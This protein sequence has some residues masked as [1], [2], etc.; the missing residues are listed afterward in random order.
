MEFAK[1]VI[2]CLFAAIAYGVAHDQVTAHLCVEYFTIAHPPMFPTKSPFLL[3]LGWGI[4]ATWWVGLPLGLLAALAARIG[5]RPKLSL[6]DIRPMIFALV[7]LMALCALCAGVLGA[8]LVATG[9]QPVLGGWAEAI[10]RNKWI[11]FNADAWAHLASY[12]SGVT[13]G[14]AIIVYIAVRRLRMG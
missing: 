9:R 7:A 4:I 5:N 10:P 8:W 3:A 12:A 13:G 1:I 6:S 2:F 11:A 14:V